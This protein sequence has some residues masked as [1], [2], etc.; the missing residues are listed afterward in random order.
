MPKNS[1]STYSVSFRVRRTTTEYA[2]VS[3]P[4]TADLTISQPDGTGR[5]DVPMM[6]HRAVEMARAPDVSWQREEQ[7]VEPHPVQIAPSEPGKG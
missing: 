6:V 2:F 1:D 5:I 3:V 7:L 4:L